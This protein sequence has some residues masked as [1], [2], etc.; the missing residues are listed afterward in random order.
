M[1]AVT[2]IEV[3]GTLLLA[4]S[5]TARSAASND[6]LSPTALTASAD[7]QRLYVSCATANELVAFNL[8]TGTIA[9]HI[10]VPVSPL[11]TALSPD[12]KTLAVACA[13]PESTICLVN[14]EQGKVVAKIPAGH[15]TMAP[16][17]NPDGKTLYVCNRFNNEVAFIDLGLRKTIQT[18]RVPREPVAASITPDGK[19]L[20]VANHIHAG[21]ADVDVVAAA[22]SVIDTASGKVT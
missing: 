22:V 21:R 3:L 20:F 15:T 19:L 11:G 8:A 12:G 18:V 17:F 9:E 5:F 10:P 2:L 14:A 4:S 6:Y 1:Q 13:A 7:G 16:V